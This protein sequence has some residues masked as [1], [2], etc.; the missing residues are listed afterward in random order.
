MVD[1]ALKVLDKDRLYFYSDN[2]ELYKRTIEMYQDFIKRIEDL[3]YQSIYNEYVKYDYEPFAVNGFRVTCDI[4]TVR[5][6]AE[7]LYYLIDNYLNN[8]NILEDSYKLK[9]YTDE[10][11][12]RV[13]IK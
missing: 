12:P 2:A 9:S 7:F 6:Q 8:M 13:K 4:V 1:Y 5:N 10:L 11:H 3:T